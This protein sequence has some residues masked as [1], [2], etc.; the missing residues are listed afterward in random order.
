MI[1]KIL[2]LVAICALFSFV[3]ADEALDTAQQTEMVAAHNKYRKE[4]EH[5]I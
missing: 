1:H 4:L 5:L 2:K 3:Y